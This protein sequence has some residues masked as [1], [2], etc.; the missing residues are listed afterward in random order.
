MPRKLYIW[1]IWKWRNYCCKMNEYTRNIRKFYS[2]ISKRFYWTAIDIWW[3]RIVIGNCAADLWN[4]KK[5]EILK[6][7]SSII[8]GFGLVLWCVDLLHF[9]FFFFS[10]KPSK[11]P[12]R[13]NQITH[14]F[15]F[16]I[17][18]ILQFN[19]FCWFDWFAMIL[20]SHKK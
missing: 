17:D 15:H 9:L 16:D 14:N 6:R 18:C 13:V 2:I 3:A 4:Q 7:K 19:N 10:K 12:R 11:I 5:Y 8:I 1:V 20:G